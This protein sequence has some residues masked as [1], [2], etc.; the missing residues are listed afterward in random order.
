MGI[1]SPAALAAGV[2]A[3]PAAAAPDGRYDLV[4]SPGFID[5]PGWSEYNLL[6]DNRAASKITQ[7]VTTE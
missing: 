3:V 5:M 1:G 4:L 2:I 6:V 7:G